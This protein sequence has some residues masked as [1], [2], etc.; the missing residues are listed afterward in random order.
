MNLD[1]CVNVCFK[2]CKFGKMLRFIKAGYG[3]QIY[4]LSIEIFIIKVY[5]NFLTH[6]MMPASPLFQSQSHCKKGK[7]HTSI[8]CHSEVL[9]N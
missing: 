7:I 1:K 3:T 9:A 4:F 5:S 6:S 2:Q 8:F